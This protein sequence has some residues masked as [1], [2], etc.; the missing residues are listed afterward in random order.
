MI[1]IV[2]ENGED[3]AERLINQAVMKMVVVT[4]LI[5][6]VAITVMEEKKETSNDEK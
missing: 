4:M 5:R 6:T 2:T 1:L 3:G